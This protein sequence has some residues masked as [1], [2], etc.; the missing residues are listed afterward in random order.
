MIVSTGVVCGIYGCGRLYE[1]TAGKRTTCPE[2]GCSEE[3][4]ELFGTNDRH[5]IYDEVWRR[6][7]MTCDG[8]KPQDL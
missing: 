6:N 8:N 2:C 4:I 7:E 3:H 1:E 5:V